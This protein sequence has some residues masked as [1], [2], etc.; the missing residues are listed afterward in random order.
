MTTDNLILIMV[1]TN[2]L[3]GI[4]VILLIIYLIKKIIKTMGNRSALIAAYKTNSQPEGEIYKNQTIGLGGAIRYRS[5]STIGISPS[6]LFISISYFG[7]RKPQMLIPWSEI[8]KVSQ[9]RLYGR[10]ACKLFIGSPLINTIR[11]YTPIF[12]AMEPYLVGKLDR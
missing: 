5:C 7:S 9:A 10:G 11:V 3:F 12:L 2:L 8:K 1:A 6:G 4:G